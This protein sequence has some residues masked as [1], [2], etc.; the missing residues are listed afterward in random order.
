MPEKHLDPHRG[1][2]LIRDCGRPTS[3]EWN[4]LEDCRGCNDWFISFATL[5]RKA[6]FQVSFEIPEYKCPDRRQAA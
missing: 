4:H 5:A 3:A 1:W 2:A 6:G